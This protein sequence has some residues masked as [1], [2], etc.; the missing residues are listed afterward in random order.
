LNPCFAEESNVKIAYKGECKD[1]Q[2][3]GDCKDEFKPVCGTD[4]RS[5]KNICEALDNKVKMLYEG[6]CGEEVKKEEPVETSTYNICSKEEKALVCGADGLTYF[7]K[8]FAGAAKVKV[9]YS[10]ECGQKAVK[11]PDLCTDYYEPVCGVDGKTYLNSC[12]AEMRNEVKIASKGK[13][14]ESEMPKASESTTAAPTTPVPYTACDR[15]I[16]ALVCGQNGLTYLNKCFAEESNV[17]IEYIGECKVVSQPK[18]AEPTST[19]APTPVAPTAVAP[20]PA[21][22]TTTLSCS[23]DAAYVC[24]ANG[25]TYLNECLAK[26]NNVTVAYKGQCQVTTTSSV[27]PTTEKIGTPSIL[28]PV[29]TVLKPVISTFAAS[30]TAIAIKQSSTLSWVV[31]GADSVI[32]AN[33]KESLPVSGKK[34]VTPVGTTTYTITATNKAGSVSAS[35]VIYVK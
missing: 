34:V 21:P 29:V 22:T 16:K 1:E 32:L 5:Y 18:V 10:G 8:C 30:P 6:K 14:G 31:S 4:G 15:N 9:V 2:K 20:T 28:I 24:G 17:K 23:K 7:N 25:L 11:S 12:E 19:V 13:C 27:A 3:S 35:V 26:Q 33:T